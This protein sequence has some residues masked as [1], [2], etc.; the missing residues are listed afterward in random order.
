MGKQGVGICLGK[1]GAVAADCAGKRLMGAEM[2]LAGAQSTLLATY[3]NTLSLLIGDKRTD[4]ALRGTVQRIIGAERLVCSRRPLFP[5]PLAMA[6]HNGEQRVR[7]MAKGET[8][9]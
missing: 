5:S 3:L 4:R 1:R 8:T 2:S 7:R 9:K 6:S